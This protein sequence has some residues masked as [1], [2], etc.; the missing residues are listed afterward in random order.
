MQH[1]VLLGDSIC[2][3]A[4]YVAAETA[5]AI[6]NDRI[7]RAAFARNLPLMDLRL[8]WDEDSDFANPIEPS[9]HGGAK[10]AAAI[11]TLILEHDFGR[12]RSG[13]YSR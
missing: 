5:L 9:V 10:I 12:M 8:V 3:N 1:V 6:I 13:V 4:A 11:A 2:D 7:T